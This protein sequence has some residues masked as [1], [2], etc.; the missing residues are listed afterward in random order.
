MPF[1]SGKCN[2]I[3]TVLQLYSGTGN[4]KLTAISVNGF[5]APIFEVFVI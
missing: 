5:E 1:V 2:D 4:L 3:V